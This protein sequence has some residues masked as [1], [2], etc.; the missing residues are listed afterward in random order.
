[1]GSPRAGLN[2][3]IG[4]STAEFSAGSTL[5]SNSGKSYLTKTYAGNP[6]S[7]KIIT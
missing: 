3:T 2:A 6:T 7:N 1:M 4:Q 5:F